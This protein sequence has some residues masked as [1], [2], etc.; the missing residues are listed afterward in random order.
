MGYRR[1]AA[2]L[3][4]FEKLRQRGAHQAAQGEDAKDIYKR[5][6]VSLIQQRAVPSREPSPE[7]L[8]PFAMPAENR[9]RLDDQEGR[10]PLTPDF[11]ELD[12][13]EAISWAQLRSR[14]AALINRQLLSEE[15]GRA[16]CRERV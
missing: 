11:G 12:P 13:G 16:S 7:E 15:I 3:R 6:Q 8:K 5:E 14:M 9:L 4:L 1:A 10:A 2:P